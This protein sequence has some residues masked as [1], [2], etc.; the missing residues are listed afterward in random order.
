MHMKPKEKEKAKVQNNQKEK[1]KPIEEEEIDD[2][3][4]DELMEEEDLDD[5]YDDDD[6]EEMELFWKLAV[7]PKVESPLEQT[8]L[9]GIICVTNACFGQDVKKNSR[10]IV[11]CK[12]SLS[13]EPTPICVL[14]QGIHENERLDL[15]FGSPAIFTLQGHDPSTVYLTGYINGGMRDMDDIPEDYDMEE[16]LGA[17]LKDRYPMEV[18]DEEMFPPEPDT[19]KEK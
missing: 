3:D 14:N 13:E 19:K 4:E 7:N 15:K 11:C 2:M 16:V 12:T 18:E 10:T 9:N 8:A 1:K 5:E 6:D 17:K